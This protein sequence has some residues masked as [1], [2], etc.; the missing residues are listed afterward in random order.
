MQFGDV[1]TRPSLTGG[2][3]NARTPSRTQRRLVCHLCGKT[4]HGHG[5]GARYRDRHGRQVD[6]PLC[7]GCRII[8]AGG[9]FA[10][11]VTAGLAEIAAGSIAMGLGGYLT[12]QDRQ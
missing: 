7:P 12:G 4:F 2:E 9:L 11:V 10:L 5:D 1:R 6:V 8:R 3:Q